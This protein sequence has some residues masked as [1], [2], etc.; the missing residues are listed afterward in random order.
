MGV[1]V[2]NVPNTIYYLA[3]MVSIFSITKIVSPKNI[4]ENDKNLTKKASASIVSI[5][6]RN[7]LLDTYK[8]EWNE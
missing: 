6:L 7:P 3:K 8:C 1:L 4:G 5:Q 2:C